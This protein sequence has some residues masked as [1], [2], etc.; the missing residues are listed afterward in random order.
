MCY[1]DAIVGPSPLFL[2]GAVF[3]VAV[4]VLLLCGIALVT[5]GFMKVKQK[6]E[7]EKDDTK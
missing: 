4:G 1:L 5:L 6:K 2:G 7:K 3:V